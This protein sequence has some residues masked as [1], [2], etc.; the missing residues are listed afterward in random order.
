MSRIAGLLQTEYRNFNDTILVESSF[1]QVN[2][3]GK[4]I[5][6]VQLGWLQHNF[7]NCYL[8]AQTI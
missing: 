2:S 5:R 7:A 6:Q 4:G 3:N 8:I 1:A